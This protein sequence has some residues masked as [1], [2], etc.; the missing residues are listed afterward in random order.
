VAIEIALATVL[1]I[2]AGLLLRTFAFL[3][4]VDPGFHGRNVLACHVILPYGQYRTGRE[5]AAFFDRVLERVRSLPGIRSAAAIDNLPVSGAGGGTWIHVEGRPEPPPGQQLNVMV[6]TVTPGYF[7]TLGVPLYAGRDF[8]DADTGV[9]DLLKPIDPKTSRLKVIVNQ[10]LID[11][12]LRGE[13]ALGRHLAIFWGQTLVGEI[14]G[15]VANVRY[16]SLA[17]EAE[18][19]FYWPEAQRPQGLMHLV[20]RTAG[21]PADWAGALRGAVQSV[22]QNVPVA[23]VETLNEVVSLAGSR[24]CFS[25]VLLGA[26]AGMALI[27]AAVGLFGVM[28]Y[29]VAQRTQEIGVR[30]ALGAKPS[31]IV[32]LV[33]RNGLT[34]VVIGLATGTL[35]AIGLSRLIAS[36]LYGVRPLDPLTYMLAL[37]V[38][39]A[40]ATLAAFVP[41]WR[42][43]KIDPILALRWE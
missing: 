21:R 15:V 3:R 31:G 41:A 43:S 29:G 39:L 24:T 36:L 6:R 20:I 37:G 22:D 33:L 9:L 19:T 2:A 32:A 18:P 35:A 12:F 7:A 34:L 17:E 8:T 14:I 38:L 25:L 23:D 11:H 30:M 4:N 42:A 16:Q 26:F 5:Q 27:L 13:S 40:V 1:L 28:A 10:A